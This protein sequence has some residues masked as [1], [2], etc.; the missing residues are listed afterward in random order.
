MT[1]GSP[2]STLIVVKIDSEKFVIVHEN[3]HGSSLS[4]GN[5]LSN[6]N[7]LASAVRSTLTF[8]SKELFPE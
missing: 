6:S 3:S 2:D 5:L 7:T 8:Q 4:F 1:S